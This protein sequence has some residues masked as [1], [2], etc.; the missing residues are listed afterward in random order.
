[1][2]ILTDTWTAGIVAGTPVDAA[3]LVSIFN[4]IQSSVNNVANTQI[5]GVDGSKLVDLSVATAKLANNAVT[6]AK[7]NTAAI[8]DALLDYTSV[9]IVRSPHINN[10]KMIWGQLSAAAA[11]AATQDFAITFTTHATPATSVT[12]FSSAT[13]LQ[14]TAIAQSPNSTDILCCFQKGAATTTTVTFTVHRAD[15]ALLNTGGTPIIVHWIAIGP[16]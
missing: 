6:T 15:G 9:K 16:N 5:T 4:A 7:I 14:I 8:T 2:A 12:T 10:Y 13:N 1:M 11:A 3:E